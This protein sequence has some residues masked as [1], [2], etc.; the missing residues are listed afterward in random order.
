MAQLSFPGVEQRLPIVA[1][2]GSGPLTQR[3][4]PRPE[5][6]SWTTESCTTVQYMRVVRWAA[7]V[8]SDRADA[9][10]ASRNWGNRPRHNSFGNQEGGAD[11]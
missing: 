2:G 10:E 6:H 1:W 11:A 7:S 9:T 4:L 3:Q 5:D 8:G